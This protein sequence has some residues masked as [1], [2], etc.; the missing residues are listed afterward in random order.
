M[1]ECCNCVYKSDAL[2]EKEKMVRGI[3]YSLLL[4]MVWIPFYADPENIQKI[5]SYKVLLTTFFLSHL[6]A[7][8][9][10]I[11]IGC[12]KKNCWARKVFHIY[13]NPFIYCIQLQLRG[14][15]NFRKRMLLINT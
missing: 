4:S 13:Q 14:I 15:I 9:L 10:G 11:F 2:S 6:V 1:M 8:L 5:T 7:L 3:S 12:A